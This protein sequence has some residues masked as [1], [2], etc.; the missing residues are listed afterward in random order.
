MP[1]KTD[2]KSE[3]SN[4][5]MEKQIHRLQREIALVTPPKV[6]NRLVTVSQVIG[7]ARNTTTV[8]D[9]L[10]TTSWSGNGFY[11]FNNVSSTPIYGGVPQRD[12]LDLYFK[13]YKYWTPKRVKITVLP[14]QPYWNSTTNVNLIKARPMYV[15]HDLD[16]E[17]GQFD[18]L[19]KMAAKGTKPFHCH[20]PLTKFSHTYSDL[21]RLAL[22]KQQKEWF[23]TNG[24]WNAR[25]QLRNPAC[26]QLQMVDPYQTVAPAQDSFCDVYFELQIM[27][28]D[29]VD[30]ADPVL[31]DVQPQTAQINQLSQISSCSPAVKE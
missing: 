27:C 8:N 1:R 13:L 16:L 15:V 3:P 5:T 6:E 29:R 25:E 31:A 9:G 21:D 19:Q 30:P 28:S 14:Y 10:S 22:Q 2:K 11:R 17:M 26:I 24:S 7:I 23:L 4:E 18:F 12:Q 20:A